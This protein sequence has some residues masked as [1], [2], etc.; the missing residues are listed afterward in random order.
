M[1][2]FAQPAWLSAAAFAPCFAAQPESEMYPLHSAAMAVMAS[3]ETNVIPNT[4]FR[5]Q[6]SLG[7]CQ[8]YRLYSTRG[9]VGKFARVNSG[10]RSRPEG[11]L[12]RKARNG[13]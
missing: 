1:Q 7:W 12:W 11:L 10:R 6:P 8:S 13:G 9:I 3:A 4:N 5:I 2:P